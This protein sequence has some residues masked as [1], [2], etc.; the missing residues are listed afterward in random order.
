MLDMYA[1]GDENSIIHILK[2]HENILSGEVENMIIYQD[3][4]C[5]GV[6]IKNGIRTKKQNMF[7]KKIWKSRYEYKPR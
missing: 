4:I 6:I 1:V 3:D 7:W 5:I 2:S